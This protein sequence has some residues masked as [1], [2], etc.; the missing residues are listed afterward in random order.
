MKRDLR[1]ETEKGA[2]VHVD[3]TKDT[4]LHNG[5][6]VKGKLRA[7]AAVNV[8]STVLAAK[9]VRFGSKKKK[10]AFLKY[11]AFLCLQYISLAT[12]VTFWISLL[13]G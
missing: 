2:K 11:T 8:P 6:D 10:N 4:L 1:H 12:I 9:P 3:A 7:T 5:H 13:S